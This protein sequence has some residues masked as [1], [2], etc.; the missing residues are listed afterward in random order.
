MQ[1]IFFEDWAG[2][3]R[4]VI[5]A[6]C[7]FAGIVVGV[8]I[9]GKRSTSRLNS[10]DWIVTVAI[11]G[12]A[13]SSIVL[14]NVTV[15]EGLAAVYSLLAMQWM[16]TTA[17]GKSSALSGMLRA[18]PRLLVHQGRILE[19]AMGEERVSEHEVRAAVRESGLHSIADDVAAV[20]LE[21]DAS[22]SVLPSRSGV[23]TSPEILEDVDGAAGH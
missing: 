3:F 15:F 21:A 17:A 4:A 12:V 10:F 14:A 20:V 13:A 8:R 7:V 18:E 1:E 19:G 2:I 9:A 5:A 22:L 16:V 23:S 11:G 6:P